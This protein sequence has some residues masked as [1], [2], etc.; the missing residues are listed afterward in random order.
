MCKKKT[1]E[2]YIQEVSEINSNISVLGYYIDSKTKILHECKIDG[3]KWYPTPN[4]ILSGKGC[5]ICKKTLIS[6]ALLLTHDEYVSKV[7]KI[8]NSIDVVGEYIDARTPIPH[9]CKI[10]GYLWDAAPTNVLR[11]TGC[12]LCAGNLKKTDSQY[13]KDVANVNDSIKVLGQYINA[14]TPILHECKNDGCQWMSKPTNI[15]SGEGCP[16]CRESSGEKIINKYLV[17]NHVEFIQQYTFTKCKNIKP[18][19]FDFYLP[20][21]NACI[22]YDGIQHFEAIDYF[23]GESELKKRQKNDSIKTNYCL[24]NDIILL[25]IKYNENAVFKLDEFFKLYNNSKLL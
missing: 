20:D 24:A 1:H 8:N 11:G 13:I 15:L 7:Y 22:E 16:K 2:E 10:D 5:P 6:K 3:H 4:S 23:G 21:Y 9:R 12:P 18:L 25:R 19:P 17:N 14:Q